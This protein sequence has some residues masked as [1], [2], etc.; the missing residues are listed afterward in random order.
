MCSYFRWETCVKEVAGFSNSQLYFQ[1][2]NLKSFIRLH[3]FKVANQKH[4]L[5]NIQQYLQS[6]NLLI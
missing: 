1:E 2:G 4:I 6:N 3:S 5:N